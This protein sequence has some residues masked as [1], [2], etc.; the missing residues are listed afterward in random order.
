MK[1][2]SI[3]KVGSRHYSFG[4][5][6]LGLSFPNGFDGSKDPGSMIPNWGGMQK[7]RRESREQEDCLGKRD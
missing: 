2:T 6:T 5:I 4:D 3:G 7:L 1:R